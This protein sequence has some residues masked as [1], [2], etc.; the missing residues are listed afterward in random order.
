MKLNKLAEFYHGCLDFSPQGFSLSYVVK[1][2]FNLVLTLVIV[3][4]WILASQEHV[5]LNTS[6]QCRV[7]LN[8]TYSFD[9]MEGKEI[10]TPNNIPM[11]GKIPLTKIKILMVILK[12]FKNFM[13]SWRTLKKSDTWD[14][15][16]RERTLIYINVL[17]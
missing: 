16:H 4:H 8:A 6:V 11:F 1:L 17:I 14:E 9:T 10:Q 12:I 13:I 3:G 5:R 15:K 2:D 7:S